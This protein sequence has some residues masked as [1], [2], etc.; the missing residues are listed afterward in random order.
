[1]KCEETRPLLYR[2]VD[3]A[4]LEED[5]AAVR[6]HLEDCRTC[7]ARLSRVMEL[8]E[9]VGVVEDE[10]PS[11]RLRQSVL[12][13]YRARTSTSSE[14]KATRRSGVPFARVAAL[15]AI[16]IGLSSGMTALAI[17][18]GSMVPAAEQ[19]SASAVAPIETSFPL[20]TTDSYSVVRADG[21]REIG[22]KTRVIN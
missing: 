16:S 20:V 19:G 7:A 8:E 21:V 22:W 12:A 9:L 18:R 4:L 2:F 11:P 1:M 10:F 3:H 14:N 15:I 13:A 5:A 6:S 17:K